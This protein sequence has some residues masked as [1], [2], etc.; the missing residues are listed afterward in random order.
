MVRELT[1]RSNRATPLAKM[2]EFLQSCIELKDILSLIAGMAPKIL[3]E[4]GGAVL[5]FNSARD[6][7]ELAASWSDCHLPA[8]VFSP[9]DCCAHR[10]PGMLIA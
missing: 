8:S 6:S 7:L 10:G 2:A 9:Q 3:P 1:R 4:L 5:L